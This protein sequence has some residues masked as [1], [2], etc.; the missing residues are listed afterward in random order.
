[1]DTDFLSL[2]EDRWN[3]LRRA[4]DCAQ[5]LSVASRPAPRQLLIEVETREA[6]ATIAAQETPRTLEI[7]VYRFRNVRTLCEGFCATEAE[8]ERRLVSLSVDL[9][10]SPFA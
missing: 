3:A 6:K 8:L 9:S 7:T 4:A 5:T 10:A 2:V 1:M